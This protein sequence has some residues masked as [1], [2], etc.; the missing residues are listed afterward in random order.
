M[1]RLILFILLLVSVL[2]A[3]AATYTVTNANNA[4]AGSLRDAISQANANP[5]ADTIDFDTAG[6]FSTS[7]TITLGGG[8]LVVTG[9]VT[10]DAPSATSKRVTV[11]GDNASRVLSV[12]L[13][14]AGTV[15]LKHLT[16]RSGNPGTTEDGGG[17]QMASPAGS[18][19]ELVDCDVR[20]SSARDGGGIDAGSSALVLTN[21]TVAYN[22]ASR[23]GGGIIAHA[24]VTMSNSAAYTNT[25][26]SDGG[27]IVADGAVVTM[28]NVS[29]FDLNTA[30]GG[31]GVFAKN[32][33]TVTATGGHISHNTASTDGGGVL[34]VGSSTV[35]LLGVKLEY[36]D[37]NHGGGISI[38]SSTLEATNCLI[39]RNACSLYGSGGGIH[40]R[41]GTAR[42]KNCTVMA[43]D[44]PS[45][46]CG[47]RTEAAGM[48]VGNTVIA[49]NPA[50]GISDTSGTFV[51]LGHNLIGFLDLATGF[52][53]GVDG[54]IVGGSFNTPGVDAKLDF[55]GNTFTPLP[56]SRCLEGGDSALVTNPPYGTPPFV[57]YF[58]NPRIRGVVDIGAVEGT[59]NAVITNDA[60]SG[61]GSLR[62]ALASSP[63]DISFDPAY[64]GT[65]LR[66]ITL[67]SGQIVLNTNLTIA[68]PAP[69]VKI[70]GSNSSRI[71]SITGGAVTLRHVRIID[72]N[73][74]GDGGG[75]RV[76]NNGTSLTLEDSGVS[77]SVA[78]GRGGGLYMQDT[79]TVSVTTSTFS[80]NV[81]D[82]GGGIHV[83]TGATFAL[84][85]STVSGNSSKGGGGGIYS[86][87]GTSTIIN[88]TVAENI[89]D[90][91]NAGAV[92]N[93][94]GI[95]RNAGTV[96]VGNTIV[97]KN[98]DASTS[99]EHP[100]VSGVFVSLGHN[101]IGKTNGLDG[102]SG[103]P[104]QNG[105]NGDIAG[106]IASPLLP[107]LGSLQLN[108]ANSPTRV[109]PLLIASPARNA[110]DAALLTNAAW[111][112]TPVANDQRG[113]F[114]T[115]GTAVDIG[116]VEFPDSLLVK[117]TVDATG[118]SEQ[119]LQ[120]V[121]FRIRRSYDD[122]A[123]LVV[124]LTVDAIT[125]ASGADYSLSGASYT[126]T[127]PTTFTV[128]IPAGK[129][130]VLLTLT[131]LQDTT[132]EGVEILALTLAAGAG[133]GLDAAETNTRTVT[134]YDNEYTV[135]SS[136]S[137]GPGTL[138]E[139]INN[140]NAGGGGVIT[141]PAGTSVTLGGSELSITSGIEI[142]G[143]NTT[144]NAAG[145]SRVFKVDYLN[146]YYG[147]GTVILRNL[148]I[149]GG[150][151]AS[152][153]Y[154]GGVEVLAYSEVEMRGC[155]VKG[156][157]A[158]IQGGGIFADA[159]ATLTLTN[160][161]IVDNVS[162][163]NGGGLATN[164]TTLNATNVT[165]AGNQARGGG[166]GYYG[167]L[168]TNYFTNCTITENLA[169]SDNT[170][171]FSENGGGIYAVVGTTVGLF[172]TVVSGNWDTPGNAGG[173][174]IN[175]DISGGANFAGSSHNF[176]G[177]NTGATASFP[178]GLPGASGNYAGSAASP[179]DAGLLRIN[180][181][182]DTYYEFAIGSLLF[183]NGSNAYVGTANDQRGYARIYNGTAD[184]GAIEM[185][186]LL[187][188]NDATTGAGSLRQALADA[189]A[190]GHGTVV[191]G[192]TFF[193][194]PRT[195]SP[196]VNGEL[197]IT[198]PLIITAPTDPARRLSV[199]GGNT[200]RVF[201]IAP[202]ALSNVEFRNFDIIN[203]NTASYGAGNRFGAGMLVAANANVT[204]T[205]CAVRNCSALAEGGGVIIAAN[206]SLA[207]ADCTFSDNHAGTQGGA[208]LNLG[209]LT[210]D[211]VTLNDNTATLEG[212]GLGNAH[213]ATLMNCTF[214]NNRA[215]SHGGA[216]YNLAGAADVLALT[217]CTLTL[218]RASDDNT[219]GGTGGGIRRVSGIVNAR[220]TIISGNDAL[221]STQ[222]DISGAFT[223]LGNNL[224][225]TVIGG[226]GFTNGVNGDLIG[227]NAYLG[228][229]QFNGG[230]TLTHAILAGSAA[231]NAASTIAGATD[232]RGL[233]RNVGPA[234]IGAYE[235]LT[236]TYAYWAAHTFPG[237]TNTGMNQDYDGDGFTN[238]FEFGAGSDPLSALSVPGVTTM[239][240]GSNFV[241]EFTAS[242]LAPFGYDTLRYSTNLV[243]WQN[244]AT[245]VYQIVGANPVQN[246]VIYRVTV[247]QSFA[248]NL[249]FRLER[250]P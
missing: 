9:A 234:D 156:N 38:S 13:P 149:T 122:G 248:P 105:V 66:T 190:L 136:A 250:L 73:S 125:T 77:N 30:A 80:G 41:S 239:V 14:G 208:I 1:K 107:Q 119:T 222:D 12:Q 215:N 88:C 76:I 106:T 104:F 120:P 170:G 63:T 19:L 134:I 163:G 211:R 20:N 8:Q 82:D 47:I 201:R 224:I 247:P 206:S 45:G 219:G 146:S 191:F 31:A 223:S 70:S 101:L 67:T 69:G 109:H 7:Q 52:T 60:D 147:G 74:T 85:N 37:A 186:F 153:D 164:Y 192:T 203:G 202:V 26:G 209:T 108:P 193:S 117:L 65:V 128:T 214:S 50:Y 152:A 178:A 167:T 98:T 78:T 2:S 96:N 124:N 15:T 48:S 4:G 171:S 27:G 22:N 225:G 81:A 23:N 183:D 84:T 249:F 165:L 242:V 140:A 24:T 216:I 68:G 151:G 159:Y 246:A 58:G 79:A 189:A 231:F 129:T 143:N 121:A 217:H 130:S 176:I 100:D 94:G 133:Y 49:Q 187:V 97:A 39:V 42:V 175:P 21:S 198:S 91:D 180:G 51:S 112:S 36:N 34:A 158:Q 5:G 17:I 131:P 173:G 210:L 194:V 59:F 200:D 145:L 103:T 18:T 148:V 83:G 221:A 179:L 138:R 35:T 33:A 53:N 99:T 90:S 86:G 236:E 102:S 230:Y 62:D 235:L 155:T 132:P 227:A 207:A 162:V 161:A 127:G 204:M 46:M 111:P 212:A 184:I 29:Y 141:V 172:N 61:A 71:F 195:I 72:G 11:S 126:V 135:S 244:V 232:Q 150:G 181:P 174:T 118:T 16:L 144:I 237:T 87:G 241:V 182:T 238:A 169:D 139:A 213:L 197:V 123:S 89:A 160:T 43:N 114:R 6:V 199:S 166:G 75:I 32:A 226:T 115:V 154:G 44:G 25:A 56:A 220:N 205:G 157:T 64:F 93:G 142:V 28:T 116:A 177:I 245:N 240:S 233:L 110:G 3:H 57:D 137:S 218:N 185:D 188:S 228:P 243:A 196:G 10:I 113:Q 92:G 95:R 55:L 168:G 54:D 40:F 229:L